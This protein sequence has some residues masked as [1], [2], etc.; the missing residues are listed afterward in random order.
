MKKI[1][2]FLIEFAFLMGIIFYFFLPPYAF[3]SRSQNPENFLKNPCGDSQR[4]YFLE[5]SCDHKWEFENY[6][7]DKKAPILEPY[8]FDRS[9]NYNFYLDNT[10]SADEKFLKNLYTIYQNFKKEIID[11]NS[12]KITEISEKYHKK[13]H[14]KIETIS[15]ETEKN[16]WKILGLNIENITIKYRN[17]PKN[18]CDTFS[19]RTK[20][21]KSIPENEEYST[22]FSGISE[23]S[24]T[25]NENV[26]IFYNDY[27]ISS[28]GCYVGQTWMIKNGEKKI[29]LD[30]IPL[31][32]RQE[33]CAVEV[34]PVSTDTIALLVCTESGYSGECEGYAFLYDTA[35]E[36]MSYL[37]AWDYNPWFRFSIES[38]I[39][40]DKHNKEEIKKYYTDIIANLE[41]E[42]AEYLKYQNREELFNQEKKYLERSY[43][44]YKKVS[45]YMKNAHNTEIA[46]FE[47]EKFLSYF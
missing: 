43:D 34:T 21:K 30:H 25:L 39:F 10:I 6:I 19:D 22:R 45:D 37:S 31:N 46:P 44:I 17:C 7:Y 26:E 5:N 24:F 27:E 36:K 40:F 29:I 38:A 9:A 12:E 4:Y 32:E 8:Q 2:L 47:A 18:L 41:N 15:D 11:Q 42:S 14:K 13:I 33:L 35:K 23:Y 3:I 1:Y 20:T 16:F 28:F